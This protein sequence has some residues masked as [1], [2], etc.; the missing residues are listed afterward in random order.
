MIK[1]ASQKTLTILKEHYG[2][3]HSVVQATSI[4]FQSISALLLLYVLYGFIKE[5]VN[6]FKKKA[7]TPK[8]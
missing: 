3:D 5:G 2:E 6:R 7:S 1:L 8:N 4:G